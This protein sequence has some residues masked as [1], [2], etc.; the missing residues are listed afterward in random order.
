[1]SIETHIAAIGRPKDAAKRAD[2]L[3]AATA[4]FLKD[5][6]ELTSMEAVAKKAD[7][8]KLTI[9][10]HFADKA[11]LFRNVIRM[12]CDKLAAPESFKALVDKPVRPALTEIATTFVTHLF[13]PEAVRLHRVI[14]AEAVRHPNMAKIFYETGPKRVRAAFGEL[15]QHYVDDGQL[16]IPDIPKATEQ[17]FSLVKG[18]AQM[19]MML[20][21]EKPSPSEMKKHVMASIDMFLAAY[22]AR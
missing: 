15:L 18:E 14:Q 10:S 11:E 22:E 8:S 4:L 19:K 2:I 20:A 9:Y 16:Q 17:F 12:R 1:M 6:Y 5:G 13:T 7:V 21:L 3:R